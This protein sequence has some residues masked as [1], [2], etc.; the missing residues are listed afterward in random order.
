[1]SKPQRNTPVIYV[2]SLLNALIEWY[3]THEQTLADG[4]DPAR[5]PAEEIAQSHT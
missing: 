2:V 3:T 4:L 1:M 5:K